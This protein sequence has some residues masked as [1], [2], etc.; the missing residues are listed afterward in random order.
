MVSRELQDVLH[1]KHVLHAI[2][3]EYRKLR[4]PLSHLELANR[5]RA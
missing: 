5:E 3:L 4:Q 1:P 2:W